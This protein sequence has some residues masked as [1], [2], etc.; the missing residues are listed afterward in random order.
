MDQPYSLAADWLSKFHT[1]PELIQALWIIAI[2][3]TVL[4]LAWIVMRGL[5]EIVLAARGEGR[6]RPWPPAR[7]R[8]PDGDGLPILTPP[9][10]SPIL[11][12]GSTPFLR[13]ED[14]RRG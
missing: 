11:S 13:N 6:A 9:P 7:T 3:V 4:G 12:R 8:Y 5:R 2:P 1:A 14:M 10:S